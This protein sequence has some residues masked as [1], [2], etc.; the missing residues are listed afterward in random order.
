MLEITIE[1]VDHEFDYLI[2]LRGN[3]TFSE[4]EK[5]KNTIYKLIQYGATRIVFDLSRLK[6]LSSEGIGVI[7][8]VMKRA[9]IKNGKVVLLDLSPTVKQI[10][11]ASDLYNL[12][13]I[14]ENR[15]DLV[16]SSEVI[17]LE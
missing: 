15:A 3:L 13:E 1:G 6:I 12:F 7:I 5:F 2:G 17:E 10:F 14:Y 9:Q 16:S 4:L 8:S 11:D